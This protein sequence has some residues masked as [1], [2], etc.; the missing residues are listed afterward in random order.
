MRAQSGKTGKGSSG[1]R[2][3]SDLKRANN[4]AK[5][6]SGRNGGAGMNRQGD[7]SKTGAYKSKPKKRK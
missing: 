2:S 7:A 4:K 1:G 6:P 3:Y 5:Y